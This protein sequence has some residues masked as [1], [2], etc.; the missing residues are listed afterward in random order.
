MKDG[1]NTTAGEFPGI[2]KWYVILHWK[3]VRDNRYIF[4]SLRVECILTE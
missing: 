3:H 4:I 1:G 2:N